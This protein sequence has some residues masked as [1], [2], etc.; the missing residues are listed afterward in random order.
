MALWD[1]PQFFRMFLEPD[2][3]AKRFKGLPKCLPETIESAPH[4]LME[5]HR[6]YSAIPIGKACLKARQ[7]IGPV[8]LAILVTVIDAPQPCSE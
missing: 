8:G 6:Q 1:S 2:A 5:I 3:K 4:K 7:E